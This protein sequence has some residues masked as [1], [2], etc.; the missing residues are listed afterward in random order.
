MTTL[1]EILV[2]RDGL[3]KRQTVQL[4][5][6]LRERVYKGEDPE[7]VLKEIGLK[8]DFIFDLMF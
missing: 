6:S 5:K 2:T 8:A 1:Q 3:T 4:I 7:Q